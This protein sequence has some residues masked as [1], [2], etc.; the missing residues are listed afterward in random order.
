MYFQKF[1][2]KKLPVFHQNFIKISNKS[3]FNRLLKTS[4]VIVGKEANV[5]WNSL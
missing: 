4:A 1:S 5:A 3:I 2:K